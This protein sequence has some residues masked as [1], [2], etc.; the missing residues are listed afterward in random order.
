MDI[1]SQLLEEIEAFMKQQGMSASAFGLEV[2]GDPRFVFDLR[3]T[4]RSPQ[5]RTV[6]FI[7]RFIARETS[8]GQSDPNSVLAS[9]G[10]APSRRSV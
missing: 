8:Q 1:R 9:A 3:N 7:R 2:M 6:E 5:L 4:K 10:D